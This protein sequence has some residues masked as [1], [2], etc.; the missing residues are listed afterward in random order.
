[1][2]QQS[3]IWRFPVFNRPWKYDEYFLLSPSTSSSSLTCAVDYAI[4][5]LD[6]DRTN[7]FWTKDAETSALDHCW[8]TDT[9][10]RA[11]SGN[12]YTRSSQVIQRSRAKR[13]RLLPY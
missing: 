1:M 12:D 2:P 4:W 6:I 7:F 8:T 11:L 9:N 13:A 10:V 3:L 5:V